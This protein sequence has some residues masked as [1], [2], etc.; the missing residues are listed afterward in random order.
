MRS[1]WPLLIT[2]LFALGCLI[3]IPEGSVAVEATLEDDEY[4]ISVDPSDPE[5]GYLEIYGEVDPGDLGIG[6]SLSVTI[7]V[8]VHELINGEATG[9]KWFAEISYDNSAIG[10]NTTLFTR[11]D[12]PES[13]T[14]IIDNA[15][16]DPASPEDV[17]P[18]PD[19]LSADAE[20]R[21]VVTAEYTG[22]GVQSGEVK[23]QA[24]IYPELYHLVTIS[25][26][27]EDV[28]LEARDLLQ[29][30]ISVKNAGNMMDTVNL[31]VPLLEYLNELDFETSLSEERFSS[32]EPGDSKNSTLSIRAPSEIKRDESL[33]LVIRGYTDS[34]DPDTL[35][36]ASK[37][38]ISINLDLEKSK[39]VKPNNTV[40]DDD[41]PA[42]DD[43]DNGF[44]PTPSPGT[45]PVA[46]D[47][48]TWIVVVVVG[49]IILAI[50]IIAVV[51]FRKGGGGDE[52]EDISDAHD[53][54]FRI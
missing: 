48:D 54:T 20:G 46:G 22:I 7:S 37:S 12:D 39:K 33:N 3:V 53:S 17:I 15:N 23:V 24:S 1:S 41:T 14:V 34:L 44:E 31:E 47:T 40:D 5:R 18:V 9:M 11:G 4:Y 16:Y 25:T 28:S 52:E 38:E 36:P 51:F 35:E 32:M 49:F 42:D 10:G 19:G 21:V 50:L 8:V 30:S 6:E 27:D 2:V 45:D 26:P 43:D 29:Y 13:F